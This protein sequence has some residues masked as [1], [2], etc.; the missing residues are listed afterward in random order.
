MV[1]IIHGA[2]ITTLLTATVVV[3]SLPYFFVHDEGHKTLVNQYEDS[4]AKV[5][6]AF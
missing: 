6:Q 3:A 1:C 2:A 4:V 5:A